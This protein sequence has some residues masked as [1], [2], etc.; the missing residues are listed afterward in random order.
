MCLLRPGC[1]DA[2]RS[3]AGAFDVGDG[4]DRDPALAFK[5]F[6]LATE[7]GDVMSTYML[8]WYHDSGFALTGEDPKRANELYSIAANKGDTT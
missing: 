7:A 8:A 2:M 6:Q 3:L 5:W 4:V 1:V